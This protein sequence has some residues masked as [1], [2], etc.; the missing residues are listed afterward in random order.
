M[1]LEE[2]QE[3]NVDDV[4]PTH[5]GGGFRVAVADVD[6]ALVLELDSASVRAQMAALADEADDDDEDAADT[7]DAADAEGSGPAAAR[8]PFGRDFGSS[9]MPDFHLSWAF[10][11]LP[12]GDEHCRL[13][14]RYRA[15]VDVEG[16]K[17][18][19]GMRIAGYGLLAGL[20]R[21][22]LGVKERVEA[23]PSVEADWPEAD[24]AAEGS[25]AE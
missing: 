20:R 8:G 10:V 11:L 24:T 19:V 7:D 21:L 9:D 16:P 18:A 4:L 17:K 12:E 15:T 2:F 14:S 22:M 6:E 13:V 23:G 5:A 3:L 25:A 1:I